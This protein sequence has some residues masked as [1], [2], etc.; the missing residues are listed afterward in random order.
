MRAS[1]QRVALS[2]W[3]L[4][5]LATCSGGVAA[6]QSNGVGVALIEAARAA[7]L[8]EAAALSN[9]SDWPASYE[10]GQLSES[11]DYIVV[12]G[13][14]A[15]SIVASRLSEQ[16]NVSVLLLEAGAQPPLESD[17]YALSGSLHHDERY[18]WLDEAQPNGNCCLARRAGS[19]C[20]WWHARMLGGGGS[21]NGN[22][23]VPGSAANFRRWRWQLQLKGWDWP[24]V[25]VAYRRLQQQLQLNFLPLQ[26]LEAQLAKLIYAAARELQLPRPRQPLL[27]GSDFGYT[28]DVPATV[29]QGRRRSSARQYLAQPQV[30]ARSNL[31][32]LL[33]AQAQRLLFKRQRAAGVQYTLGNRTLRALA[34]R[35]LVL[36]AGALNSA[37][38]LLLSGIGPA[39]ELR[40]LGIQPLRD[41][42]VGR[43]LH[44][45]GML[46][47]FLR[48]GNDCGLNASS[49]RSAYAPAS[50]AEYLLQQQRG[51]LAAG[52]SM[53]GF[54]NS[55]APHSRDGQPDLHIVAH[56]FMPRGSAGSFE[57]LGLRPELVTA[58][59]AA[60]AQAP[61]LQLM[62][63]LLLPKSRSKLQLRSADPQQ[64]PLISSAYAA[65]PADRATLL[66]FIRY[67]QLML[68]TPAFQRCGLQ[69]WLP[70]LPACD[71][72]TPD[73]DDYWLCHIRHMF[74]GAWHAVGSCRMATRND[75]RGVVD[76]RLRVFG[77]QGLRV[78][79][80][81]I[82]PE[83][84]AGNTNAPAMMIAE[85]GA[86]MIREDYNRAAAA[87]TLAETTEQP[88]DIPLYD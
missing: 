36:S 82:M 24:Q 15:G 73:S 53:M 47:L 22:I 74:L 32:V 62:G 83:I 61:M 65:D 64:P 85:Q 19:G 54:I 50:V 4:L 23:Y 77:V 57:Y 39:A 68:T 14:S 84:T 29:Q 48:F 79:D 76:E 33:A 37:K 11:Y 58:Q 10:P 41:L 56:T 51:P 25:Q 2:L 52:F 55:S 6:Q 35:E 71:A 8:S 5:L 17:I 63:S 70:P 16:R 78:V 72:L 81:S 88:N 28:H 30:R 66:R 75:P 67:V 13:G 12:G 1:E 18:M 27:M 45:H 21:L 49:S 86:R 7:L 46:P 31:R 44:D 43:N 59:R 60:L 40:A 3:L 42:P 69:L 38:L 26:P 80:A 9:S 87:A 20:N 34:K